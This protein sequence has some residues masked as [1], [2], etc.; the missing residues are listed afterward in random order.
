MPTLKRKKNYCLLYK[1]AAKI[2]FS[3]ITFRLIKFDSNCNMYPISTFSLSLPSEKALPWSLSESMKLEIKS[4]SRIIF[5]PNKFSLPNLRPPA[6]KY[7]NET[8]SQQN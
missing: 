7:L 4:S 5:K 3:R 6:N 1:S 2:Y 8:F